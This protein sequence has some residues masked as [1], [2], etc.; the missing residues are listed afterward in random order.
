MYTKRTKNSKMDKENIDKENMDKENMD[1]ENMDKENDDRKDTEEENNSMDTN[2]SEGSDTLDT[3]VDKKNEIEENKKK[4]KKAVEW[5]KPKRI[6]TDNEERSMFGKALEIMLIACMNNHV[7]QFED[8]VKIQKEGG[9]IGLKLTGEIADCLMIDWDKKLLIE[10]KKYKMTPE[11]YTR[12]KD[13]IEIA[14][15]CLERA[16]R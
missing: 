15:E 6:P 11:V 7:Y 8:K 14:I 2:I 4:K 16:V 12:F 10:L 3:S 1:K 9:P 13:D 5:L